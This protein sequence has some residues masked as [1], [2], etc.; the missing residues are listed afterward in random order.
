MCRSER[1]ARS[2]RSLGCAGFAA[3]LAAGCATPVAPPVE[4]G[5]RPESWSGRFAAN[6]LESADPPR[7]QAAS[8]R[9]F[10][11]ASGQRTE[12]DVYSPFGQTIARA[13]AGPE[14]AMLETADGV[15]HRAESPEALT[16][17]VL[18]WR[19]PVGRL[20]A[21]LGGD[22]SARPVAAAFDDADWAVSVDEATDDGTP[23]RVTLR[24][25]S[26]PPASE[27]RRVTIRLVIDGA[28]QALAPR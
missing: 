12:L 22:A 13:A 28:G 21:W 8:G 4:P 11:R 3:L 27:W 10:L 6:W 2:L 16:E 17:R 19:I 20:P 7:E 15:R 9:F 23:R 26:R 14:G 1:R 24:W 5:A 18:G 25:P